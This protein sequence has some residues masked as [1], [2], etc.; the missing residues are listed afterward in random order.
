VK[1]KL[2]KMFVLK[3]KIQLKIA[4]PKNKEEEK[5]KALIDNNNNRSSLSKITENIYTS[6]YLVAKDIPFLLKNN[7]THVINCSRGSSMETSNEQSA[8][9]NNYDKSPSIKY[10]PIFLRDDP[11]ADI[12]NC[13]FQTIDFIESKE[14][15]NRPKKILIHCIEGISR[16][17]ALIAG[18][19][20]WKQNL[21]TENAIEFVKSHRKCVDINLGF[22]IQLHKWENY[23]FSSPEKIHIFKLCKNIRLLDEKEYENENYSEIEH[24]IRFNRK[25]Y[26]IK[27]NRSSDNGKLL[28]VINK[29]NIE[30]CN[31]FNENNEKIKFICNVIKYDKLL[32]NND[33]DSLVEINYNDLSNSRFS[34]EDLIKNHNLVEQ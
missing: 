20:M 14:E 24:L 32:L 25:L 29:L 18:Y 17:P 22:I 11:G 5:S 33:I 21:R 9:A 3:K 6:G 16:A 26:Y 23:L 4:I 13:F 7:F 1:K 10:L 19:L 31:I 12:I 8:D 28:D 2:K 30:N 34:F 27:N 15:S